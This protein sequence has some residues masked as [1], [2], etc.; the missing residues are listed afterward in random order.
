MSLALKFSSLAIR[1]LSK[2]IAN[3]IKRQ[4]REHEGFRR[5]CINFAQKLHRIDMRWRIGLLQDAA[6]VEKQAAREAAQDA[7]KRHKHNIPTVKT[8]AQTKAD[9]EAAAKAAKDGTSEPN[10]P[11]SQPRIRPLSE[12]KAIESGANFISETFL[13]GV[14]ASLILLESW[15]SRKKESTRRDDVAERLA[16]LEFSEKAARHALVEL[17]REVLRL[18]AKDG[19]GTVAATKRILPREVYEAGSNSEEDTEGPS[20]GW[21]SRIAMYIS[22]KPDADKA[23][24]K[25]ALETNSPG[26]AEKILV[27][28][29]EEIAEK[30]KKRELET[31]STAYLLVL[32]HTVD[33]STVYPLVLLHTVDQSTAYLLVLLHTVDQSTAYLL[34][35][36]HTVDQSTVYPLVLLHTVDQ[37]TAYLL[38]LLHTVDQS[39]AYLLVLFHTVDQSTV[40][41]LVLLHTVDQSTAYLLVLLH[42]VD[43]STAYQLVLCHAF[44]PVWEPEEW[45][46]MASAPSQSTAVATDMTALVAGAHKTAHTRSL[47]ILL[48]TI[49]DTQAHDCVNRLRNFVSA[50]KPTNAVDLVL[51]ARDAGE[52]DNDI[53]PALCNLQIELL[54]LGHV[55]VVA[56]YSADEVVPLL[57]SIVDQIQQPLLSLAKSPA[58]C[59]AALVSYATSTAPV[60]LLSQHDSR[61]LTDLFPTIAQL[62]EATRTVQ[63][64]AAI[65][66]SL[67]AHT[68]DQVIEFWEDEWLV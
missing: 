38:V 24:A 53:L 7:A 33:Q 5:T 63:G 4:A 48:L 31:T 49:T 9:E 13:F 10:K 55:P 50:I 29:D 11:K 41:P 8:E 3:F 1:T 19:G 51:L 42:T 37:S 44:L 61:V 47:Q 17:E 25:T 27:A 12:A 21:L 43:Q 56:A 35:L 40:Y 54:D 46:G 14:A 32:F 58:T 52:S 62:A 2:P 16:D 36:F 22:S 59:T 65:R 20:Q 26:P 28:A 67:P 6:A 68:A 18:K 23:A 64:Q 60:K 45:L 30:H 15:R 34:V 39:T 66:N 57:E